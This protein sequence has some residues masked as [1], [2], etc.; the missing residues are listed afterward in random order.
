[1]EEGTEK[2]EKEQEDEGGREKDKSK[3]RK[4]WHLHIKACVAGVRSNFTVP[5]GS[6]MQPVSSGLISFLL[7]FESGPANP[8][9]GGGKEYY[10]QIGFRLKEVAR[11]SAFSALSQVHLI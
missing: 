10:W 6:W 11:H 2:E 4:K 7:H 8:K 1:M 3:W 5:V 9:A